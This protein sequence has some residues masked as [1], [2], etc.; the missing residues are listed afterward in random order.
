MTVIP[1]LDPN[2]YIVQWAHYWYITEQACYGLTGQA[3]K[4]A[5]HVHEDAAR[6][7]RQS[8]FLSK[9]KPVAKPEEASHG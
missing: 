3:L 6:Q 7:L 9:R 5:Q 1:G 4:N 8:L 2:A